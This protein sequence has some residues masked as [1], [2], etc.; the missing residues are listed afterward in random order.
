M[1]ITNRNQ[2][3]F[4]LLTLTIL[5]AS[6][7]AWD[8][9]NNYQNAINITVRNWS[10]VQSYNGI[11]KFQAPSSSV[12][13]SLNNKT[14][15][16]LYFIKGYNNLGQ[17]VG[18]VSFDLI[19]ILG[20]NNTILFQNI[21][22]AGNHWTTATIFYNP[23]IPVYGNTRALNQSQVIILSNPPQGINVS[24]NV[25]DSGFVLISNQTLIPNNLLITYFP[26]HG[27]GF[28]INTTGG[29][30]Y[31]KDLGYSD[32]H[33][34]SQSVLSDNANVVFGNLNGF[35]E[36][37]NP[38]G[39]TIP[40][41]SLLRPNTTVLYGEGLYA[42]LKQFI[43]S[44][45]IF[46]SNIPTSLDAN[47]NPQ[48]LYLKT[49]GANQ[50]LIEVIPPFTTNYITS[51]VITN[52]NANSCS[53]G[54]GNLANWYCDFQYRELIN[55]LT[56]TFNFTTYANPNSIGAN[57]MLNS[58]YSVNFG[59]DNT[60]FGLLNIPHL[61]SMGTDC[62]NIYLHGVNALEGVIPYW[63][64]NTG[65]YCQLVIPNKTT[66][67]D[68]FYGFYLYFNSPHN[69][70]GFSNT[71]VLNSWEINQGSTFNTPLFGNTPFLVNLNRPL[72]LHS[73]VGL[74]SAVVTGS[75]NFTFNNGISLWIGPTAFMKDTAGFPDTQI[76]VT[77][78]N[79]AT[80]GGNFAQVT[81]MFSKGLTAIMNSP[82]N[83]II[84]CVAQPMYTSNIVNTIRLGKPIGIH[85]FTVNV[86]AP[87][88]VVLYKL[89]T[90]SFNV[91]LIDVRP[92]Q[93]LINNSYQNGTLKPV[94]TLP[95]NTSLTEPISPL[96]PLVSIL[97]Y[98][99]A[100]LA[101][102]GLIAFSMVMHSDE[103]TAGSLGLIIM[104]LVGIFA[105]G[106]NFVILGLVLFVIF[107]MY[108]YNKGK[109]HGGH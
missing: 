95:I 38:T 35:E 12:M 65:K 93:G 107:V 87:V 13:V 61:N 47:N 3:L 56:W 30:Y 77:T 25:P 89:Y 53:A 59:P 57:S 109:K 76:I 43:I 52:S 91:G 108:E 11:L 60:L 75:T 103:V 34:F 94:I 42:N 39:V 36:Y 79:V 102:V 88:N 40:F 69:I 100:L 54:S 106:S 58:A 5:I 71:S 21:T 37:V 16:F 78:A 48:K 45:Q 14:N 96:F 70:G 2:L 50:L 74:E 81:S 55:N 82:A 26:D 51:N 49:A 8:W 24:L 68:P 73:Y 90:S 92:S 80:C 104:F 46:T 7:S 4:T 41:I 17:F 64:N 97:S 33:V 1:A 6:V 22:D 10:Y 31:L 27:N 83:E 98:V 85:D 9:D 20:Q 84:D 67:N 105:F 62:R 99:L 86:I 63:L 15:P 66:S 19:N 18:N 72:N 23:K 101:I 28:Q 29:L 32:G 44:N